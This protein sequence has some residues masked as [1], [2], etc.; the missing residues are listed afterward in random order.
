[1]VQGKNDSQQIAQATFYGP[2]NT[3]GRSNAS[4]GP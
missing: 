2:A 4:A 3:F 1:M